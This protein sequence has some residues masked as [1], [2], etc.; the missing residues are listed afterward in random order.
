MKTTL[1][2]PDELFREAKIRAAENGVTLK[3]LVTA[4]LKLALSATSDPTTP[5]PHFANFPLIKSTRTG[6]PITTQEVMQTLA[7]LETAEVIK[8]AN[9][10]RR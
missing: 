1:D 2:I 10:L 4:G 8:N 5:A 3:E 7:D 9:S 6:P